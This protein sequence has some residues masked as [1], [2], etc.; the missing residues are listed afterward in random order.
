MASEILRKAGR[1]HF[2]HE[3]RELLLR[4]MQITSAFWRRENVLVR[5]LGT[6]MLSTKTFYSIV[7]Y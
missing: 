3:V 6:C 1:E 2:Y 5:S 4:G 7:D